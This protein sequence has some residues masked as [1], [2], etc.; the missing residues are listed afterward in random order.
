MSLSI[1]DLEK[2]PLPELY[3]I[4]VEKY[5]TKWFDLEL[6]TISMDLGLEF[7]PLFYDKIQVLRLMCEAPTLFREDSVFMIYAT[8]VIND[9]SVEPEILPE[10]N[11][12]E[13]AY[14][15]VV[16]AQIRSRL[17]VAGEIFPSQGC[18]L[19]AKHVLVQDGYGSLLPPFTAFISPE[20][21]GKDVEVSEGDLAAKKKA[22][23]DYL[24]GKT[25][26]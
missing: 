7:S 10:V 20:V 15:I 11:S 24:K 14:G 21:W 9:D 4:F 3:D 26:G 12:L 13:L 23:V 2:T 17:G 18:Q 6:E 5:G 25:H 8:R 22:I 19:V 1:S 16:D